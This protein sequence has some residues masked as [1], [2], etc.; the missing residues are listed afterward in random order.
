M[1]K[2]FAEPRCNII[3]LSIIL[4]GFCL[5]QQRTL[6]SSA[7]A[8]LQTIITSS[9]VLSQT[10]S[11]WKTSSSNSDQSVFNTHCLEAIVDPITCT[12]HF[13]GVA[14]E[15]VQFIAYHFSM[16]VSRKFIMCVES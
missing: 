9:V 4:W 5:L 14:S 16:T 7:G 3:K 2:G 8:I 10:L 12:I 1:I 11:L 6:K 13:K 15:S